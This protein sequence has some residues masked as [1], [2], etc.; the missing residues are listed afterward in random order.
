VVAWTFRFF[1]KYIRKIREL[2]AVQDT[3]Q[4]VTGMY[5]IVGSDGIEYG[6]VDVAT[7]INW[8]RQGRINLGTMI[9]DN[10]TDK[11]FPAVDMPEISVLLQPPPIVAQSVNYVVTVPRTVVVDAQGRPLKNKIAAGLLAILLGPFGAHRFY[12]GY[13]STGIAMLVITIVTCGYGGVITAIWGIVEGVLCLT[14]SM[15]DA[16]GRPLSD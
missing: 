8:A 7:L 13:K 2:K 9:I 15:L 6:P 1:S 10:V 16:E 4:R 12:L 11:R 14:G 3:S 5:T